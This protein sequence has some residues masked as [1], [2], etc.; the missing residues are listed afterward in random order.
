MQMFDDVSSEFGIFMGGSSGG[1]F[2]QVGYDLYQ[3]Y[4]FLLDIDIYFY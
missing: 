1:F 4:L 2:L 3:I